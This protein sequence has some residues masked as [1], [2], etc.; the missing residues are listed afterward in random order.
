MTTPIQLLKLAQAQAS[1]QKSIESRKAADLEQDPDSPN[2]LQ[3]PEDKVGKYV[4]DGK[5][6][7]YNTGTGKNGQYIQGHEISKENSKVVILNLLEESKAP[8]SSLFKRAEV[9]KQL[10]LKEIKTPEGK[11]TGRF[12]RE[13]FVNGHEYTGEYIVRNDGTVFFTGGSHKSNSK[14]LLPP[15]T[16]INGSWYNGD[17]TLNPEVAK[18][19]SMPKADSQ[20][21]AIPSEVKIEINIPEPKFKEHILSSENIKLTPPR[22]DDSNIQKALDDIK[23]LKPIVKTTV[24]ENE[25]KMTPNQI[26]RAYGFLSEYARKIQLYYVEKGVN[27]KAIEAGNE[28]EK[29]EELRKTEPEKAKQKAP[30]MKKEPVTREKNI[31]L[32]K[33]KGKLGSVDV[34]AGAGFEINSEEQSASG[35]FGVDIE[36]K[37]G[38]IGIKTDK[39][40]ARGKILYGKECGT[41]LEA[42][43]ANA[44][45]KYNTETGEGSVSAGLSTPKLIIGDKELYI[46]GAATIGTDKLGIDAHLPVIGDIDLTISPRKIGKFFTSIFD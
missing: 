19:P 30:P 31:E 46:K 26:S 12:T 33:T 5:T 1:D 8:N 22:I 37:V 7:I 21:D 14:L 10:D 15:Q 35:G 45:A 34:K 32:L 42:G 6:F 44:S 16:F 20:P 11:L 4:D 25:D 40:A 2:L 41:E 17:V 13:G 36:A 23:R 24:Q 29:L 43:P 9:I 3:H 38:P 18:I 27:D 28:A 39:F